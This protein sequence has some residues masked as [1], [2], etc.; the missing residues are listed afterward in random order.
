L[1]INKINAKIAYFKTNYAISFAST[2]TPHP[3]FS[4]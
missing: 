4:N 3:K 1:I 2:R